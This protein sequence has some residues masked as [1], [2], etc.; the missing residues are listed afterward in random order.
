MA[1]VPLPTPTQVPV[2]STDIR[3]AVFAGAKLD[4]EVTGTGEFYTDR[5]GA[6]RLTN[7]GRNNQFD[8]AQ[9]DRANRFEQFLLSSGYVFLGDYEDGP[10]QFSARN[11]YIRYNDQYYRLNATT[12]VGFT[13]TGTDATSFANDVT[14]FVLMDGDTLRQ[15]LGSGEEGMGGY[16]VAYKSRT[17]SQRLSDKVTLTDYPGAV[18]G[19]DNDST[20]AFVAAY[21]TG[22]FVYVPAGEWFTH[23][24]IPNQTFG[25]GRI[26]CDGDGLYPDAGERVVNPGISHQ[27]NY[28]YRAETWGNKERAAG[29][30]LM[31]NNENGRP[32]VSGFNDT[33]MANY[34][35]FDQVGIFASMRGSRDFFYT[36]AANTTYTQFSIQAPE[37]TSDKKVE[38]GMLI[39]TSHSP[40][41]KGRVMSVDFST[42]TITV[43]KWV[44]EG[45]TADGQV[46][47]NNVRAVVNGADK[48]WAANFNLFIDS[49]S[50]AK[51]GCGL[52]ID[53]ITDGTHGNPVEGYTVSNA[54]NLGNPF[55]Y[56]FRALGNWQTTVYASRSQ[57]NGL[58]HVEPPGSAV[59]TQNLSATDWTGSA[60][61]LDTN[62][63]KSTSYLA[64][65]VTGGVNQ[66]S[67]TSQGVRNV[68]RESYGV[69]S[70]G[71]T[72]TGLSASEISCINAND[73]TITL[74]LSTTSFVTGQVFYVRATGGPVI[75]G[76]YTL[77]D[78][79]GRYIKFMYDGS[80]FIKRFQSN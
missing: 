52:E 6:K 33:T 23:T 19:K 77:N 66:F 39:S 43:S 11:Q 62:Y 71:T 13:T 75:V 73:T 58:T 22:R 50:P 5:L 76:G 47:P 45:N 7:T 21:A 8:A 74:N 9:L 60:L 29:W 41:Y 51:T 30:S 27:R 48:L 40:R 46:P 14:H 20:A 2:P 61:T 4:E 10:F 35:N 28:L 80:G 36:T 79:N 63:R 49:N 70:T 67:I 32:E 15:N 72:I 69:V 42:Q 3:N 17:V 78:A 38:P 56:G 54:N 18:E 64:R 31:V 44:A 24:Y 26:W 25:E 12:D 37:I 59:L 16:L 1:E 53:I 65:V 68:Q 57:S 55:N 34:A